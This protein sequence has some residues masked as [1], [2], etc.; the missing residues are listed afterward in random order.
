MRRNA[1]DGGR[2]RV[3][4]VEPAGLMWG[5]ERALLDLLSKLDTD[6]YD[7]TV[8]C[9]EQSAFVAR[10]RHLGIR[11]IVAPLQLLHQRGQSARI[12]ALAALVLAMVRIRPHIVHVN[13]A[14]YMR[15][16]SLA[17]KVVAARVVCH[18]RLFEDAIALVAAGNSRDY[19]HRLIAISHAILSVL[20]QGEYT[21]ANAECIYDPLDRA[22]V[23]RLTQGRSRAS[24]R[25]EFKIPDGACVVSLVGRVCEE[26]RQDL[27][28]EAALLGSEDIYYLIIGGDPPPEPGRQSYRELLQKRIDETN[29]GGRFIFTGMRSDVSALMLASDVVVMTT[30]NE[31]LGRVLLEAL[32][33]GIP[34]IAPAA[35]GPYEIIGK[36]ERGLG[37]AIGDASGLA[38]QI[39]ETLSDR[40]GSRARTSRGTKWVEEVCS[41]ENHARSV[42]RI[43]DEL[44]VTD[45]SS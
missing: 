23:R 26:K 19:P 43:Y 8:V 40:A 24:V 12:V 41:P 5:S 6:R 2:T 3:L 27:L 32:S 35:G 33:L 25:A 30:D 29:L 37:F 11:T 39:V 9:P 36:D 44:G 13:Q 42:E 28:I 10:L 38:A 1:L 4:V 18:V 7:V 34:V 31:P 45:R 17:S 22:E 15:L 14:G 20:N 16:A 21:K